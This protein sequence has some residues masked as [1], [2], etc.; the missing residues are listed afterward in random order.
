V[1]DDKPKG[2]SPNDWVLVAHWIR[3]EKERRKGAKKRKELELIWE[4]I[5][6]QVAM[7]PRA[8]IIQSG[9]REDWLPDLELPLQFNTL[10]VNAAD[11][12]RLKFPRG[13]E[14]YSVS[15]DLSDEYMK[16][17]QERRE[18]FPMI[19]GKPVPMKLDQETANVLVKATMDHYH[20]QYDFRAMIDLFDVECLKYG[21][22]ILRTKEVITH[23][24]FNDFRGTTALST[25]GPAV[26]PCSI[27]NVYLDDTPLAVMHEGITMAPGHIRCLYKKLKDV[28]NAIATGGPE[29]GWRQE[30]V[31]KL[32]PEKGKNENDEFVE[33]LEFEGDLVVPRGRGK[34]IFLP[35]VILTVAAGKNACE[36]VRFRESDYPF[37]SYAI[38]HYFRE[39]L[40]SPYGTSPLIKGQPIQEA[41]TAA[42]NDLMTAGALG[43]RP[44]C[45]YDRNDPTLAAAGGPAIFP[46]SSTGTDS[47]DAV[48]FMENPDV[49]ALLQ[50]YVGLTKQYEDLTAVNDPRRGGATKSHQSAYAVDLENSRGLAR[51]DDF[52]QGQE[53]GPITSVLYKEYEIVKR[54]LTK[55]Q[56]IQVDA[57]GIEGW[58]KVASADLP[59]KVAF[60]VT[61]SAGVINQRQQAENFAAATNMAIQI[62]GTAAQLGLP[63]QVDW[64]RLVQEI[65]KRAGINNSAEYVGITT[66]QAPTTPSPEA[67]GAAAG[68]GIQGPV[69][70]VPTNDLTNIQSAL[71][72]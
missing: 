65:Y 50:V 26:V 12:R 5:D 30:A 20:R 68:P 52:V 48:D 72:A 2:L 71:G 17:F 9:Q 24:F 70:G 59:D 62:I 8:R 67:G 4:E 57:G 22:G 53:V 63:I 51:I 54:C 58:V 34:P 31:K 45:F 19:G 33:L 32:E 43:A 16:R 13:S 11:A 61:G 37:C 28:Q 64:P 1:P 27:K 69:T 7:E 60:V 38:G 46:G 66:Q 56:D 21:T 36:V 35:A 10:E 3:D 14:W 23:K 44:P 18:K 41:A 47:P 6:R 39:D 15:A 55:G 42:L 25:R 49:A 29:R 40:D